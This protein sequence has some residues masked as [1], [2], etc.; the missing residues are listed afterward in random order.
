MIEVPRPW[1]K[2][3]WENESTGLL[4]LFQSLEKHPHLWRNTRILAIASDKEYSQI[5]CRNV[6]CFN[7]PSRPFSRYDTLH[8]SVPLDRLTKF[9]EQVTFH[10][11]L[12][13]FSEFYQVPCRHLFVCTHTHY[14]L[15][16]GRFGTPIYQALRQNYS[17]QQLQVWQVAHFGGHHLAPTLI[18]FPQGQFWG[19][20]EPNVLDILINRQGDVKQLYPYYRG[21]GGVSAW[22]QVLEREIW[23]KQGWEWLKIPKQEVIKTQD[24]GKLRHRLLRKLLRHVPTIRAQVLLSKLEQ[25]LSWSEIEILAGDDQKRR[26]SYRARIAVNHEIMT[27]LCSQAMDRQQPVKQYQVCW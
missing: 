8:F 1:S 16:C 18:D 11:P 26:Q 19:F 7:R 24:G 13:S 14:D 4:N 9:L 21:W 10:K 22:T 5:G 15:A 20:L 12:T 23:M 17:D 3:P 27:P 25:K 2:N 6:I